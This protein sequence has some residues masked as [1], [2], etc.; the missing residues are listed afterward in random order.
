MAEVWAELLGPDAARDRSASFLAV[1]GH[2]LLAAKLVSRLRA[3][4]GAA[5]TLRDVFADP[6]LAGLAA[7]LDREVRAAPDLAPIPRVPDGQPVRASNGQARLWYLQ[8]LDPAGVAYNV[9]LAIEL[10][11][12]FDPARF[13]RAL[14]A[15]VRRH[16]ALRTTLRTSEDGE[17]WLHVDPHATVTVRH[18]VADDDAEVARIAR[19]EARRPF[20]LAVDLPIRCLV[21]RRTPVRHLVAITLHHSASDGASVEILV[22]DL[23]AGYA[24]RDTDAPPPAVR[25]LDYAVWQR[26]T[27]SPAQLEEGSRFWRELLSGAPTVTLPPEPEAGG[28]G[29]ARRERRL[30]PAL[31]TAVRTFGDR[32]GV[33]SFMTLLAAFAVVLER[34]TGLHDLVVGTPVANR[35]RPELEPVVGFFANTLALR[36]DVGGAPSFQALVERVKAVTLGALQHQDVPFDQVV[37]LVRAPRSPDRHPVFQIRFAVQRPAVPPADIDGLEVAVVSTDSGAAR[38]DLVVDAVEDGD[39]TLLVA[40]YP[41]AR[42]TDHTVDRVLAEIERACAAGLADPDGPVAAIELAPPEVVERVLAASRG[43][44]VAPGDDVVVAVERFLRAEPD[45]E[46]IV[47]TGCVVD[48]RAFAGR[49]AA[50]AD[51]LGDAGP[52]S[53]VAVSLPRVPD[54]LAAF[55]AALWVGAAFLP[56]DPAYPSARLLATMEE[57]GATHL[58]SAEPLGAARFVPVPATGA[59]G[60]LGPPSPLAGDALAYVIATSG[61]TGRPK[62]VRIGR[63]ALSSYVRALPAGLGITTPYRA[64][65]TASFGFSSSVRQALLP[66]ATGGVVVLATEQEIADPIALAELCRRA[67][68]EVVDVV[69]TYLRA[70]RRALLDAGRSDLPGPSVRAVWCASEPLTASAVA[71]WRRAGV[72]A[73]LVNLYGQTET[74][75][76]VAGWTVPDPAPERIPIGR[77][78]PGVALEVRTPDGRRAPVGATGALWVATDRLMQGYQ[79]DRPS[80]VVC[81]DG[82]R[83]YPTGDLAAWSEDGTVTLHGRSDQQVKIRG[84]R[85]ELGEVEAAL[86]AHPDVA[87]AAAAVGPEPDPVLLAW[88]EPRAGATPQPEALRD[89]ARVR[90]PAAAVPSRIGVVATIPR[91][92]NGKVDRAA[93]ATL[94]DPSPAATART[95]EP[96]TDDERTL[97][98]LFRRVLRRDDIGI[99]DD[100][101][102]SG[103]DSLQSIRLVSR[104]RKAGIELT[105]AVFAAHPVVAEL[106]ALRS[107]PK[108]DPAPQQTLRGSAPLVPSHH[109]FLERGFQSPEHQ[110]HGFL[111]RMSSR[112]DPDAARIAVAA[113]VR[114]HDGLRLRFRQVDDEWELVH[115][116]PDRMPDVFRTQA[117][118]ATDLAQAATD[119]A[120][121]ARDALDLVRGPLLQVVHLSGDDA[122]GLLI[123]IHHQLMDNQSWGCSARTSSRR[124]TRPEPGASAASPRQDAL[125]PSGC[126]QLVDRQTEAA[127]RAGRLARC[128]SAIARSPPITRLGPGD[129]ASG[130]S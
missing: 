30:P 36:I 107:A 101:F 122:D 127:T 108:A 8:Q 91:T 41:R 68:V 70:W 74:A 44:A 50:F 21:V 1:G 121:S 93:V 67:A 34:R 86:A 75:G 88:V 28:A 73:P 39:G 33:T 45:A 24:A 89:Y 114:H 113:V 61:S 32:H 4:F 130:S 90:L 102:A 71:T 100:F 118:G 37:E 105:P 13:E 112:I 15:V 99:Y 65:H 129:A 26:A 35:P 111:F 85:V 31:A 51:A 20:D 79:G 46:A 27:S 49:V 57:A 103:G 84:N 6:T 54:A 97:L 11:G 25:Y 126:R 77:P 29:G 109:A 96:R 80:P 64:L 3:R 94:A 69:P 83:W 92:P 110:V 63:A 9:P 98:S 72:R 76:L 48:R 123:V 128:L 125:L 119:V 81:R 60:A 5:I 22:R 78:L 2:S 7:R 82:E 116:D 106:A 10:R 52:G 14:A 66:L 19:D 120:A 124:P 117:I 95:G 55:V 59:H 38:F 23:V 16:D 17:A 43:A 53:V 18:A 62:V 87:A 56:L 47:S 58:I 12:A 115:V 104:A 40:E 42:Y